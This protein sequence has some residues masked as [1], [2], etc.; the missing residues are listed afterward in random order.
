MPPLLPPD[1]TLLAPV[2]HAAARDRA[3][4]E[5]ALGS[6]AWL[7]DD[8]ARIL[9]EEQVHSRVIDLVRYASDASPYRMFPQIVVT[10]R[11]VQEI[12]QIFSYA[13]EKKL[14][15]TIRAAGS[16]L[17]GQSQGSGI[18]IDVRR[19]WAGVAV[20][21]GG[22]RLRFR[23]G[24]VMF[25]ANLALQPYGYRLGP[26]PASAGVAT[27]GG[28]IANNASG[29]CCGTTQN[30]YNTIESLS[31]L[32]A[33]GTQINTADPDAEHQF[34][35]LE[36]ELAAGLLRIREEI[37][38]DLELVERIRRKYS[39]KNTTGY[40]MAA[41]LDEKSPLNI[42]RRL[43]V[44]SE[45]TLAFISEGVFRTVPDN[46]FRLTA[47]LLFPDMHAACAAVPTFVAASAAAVELCDRE[48]L[49]AVE[50]RPGIPDEWRR[51]PPGAT[52]LL[53][54]F[55]EP[56]LKAIGE[57][58]DKARSILEQLALLEPAE[59]TRNPDLREQ[60][61]AVRH[62]LLPSIGGARASGTSLILEDVCFPK[63]TLADGALDLQ[64]LFSKHSYKGVVFGHASAGNLHFL[65]TPSLSSDHD[66]QL[67]DA[68]LRDVVE[69]VTGKY[70]GSL[71]AEHGT[72]RNIAPFV[73]REW[74]PKLTDMMWRVKRLADP[75]NILSPDVVLTRNETGH[76]Q[77]LHTIPTVEPEID[78]CIEC[79][80]CEPVCPSRHITTTPRQRITLRREMRRQPAGSEITA[81]IL[82][83]YQYDAIETCAGDG[84]C[85]LACPVGIDTGALMKKFRHTEQSGVS[86]SVA[87][88]VAENWA[89]AE[90]F[91]RGALRLNRLAA[92]IPGGTFV[93]ANALKAAR[94]VL[95]EDLIPSI[96][97]NMPG[98]AM[99]PIPATSRKGA[100]AVYYHACVN[101]I[102][103]SQPDKVQPDLAQAL[104]LIS[105]RAQMPVWIPE[106][107][108]GTCCAT[109][110]RSKGYA[111]GNL[112]MANKLVER[113]WE[114]SREGEIPIVC[115]A[116]S[117]SFGMM[118]ELREYLSKL[119][120]K[121][122]TQL[123]IMDSIVWAHDYLLPQ[124]E[125]ERKVSSAAI[126]PTCS[127]RHLGLVSKLQRLA[128]ALAERVVIPIEATCCGFAGDRGFLHPELT[129][130]ATEEH[131]QELAGKQ[132][133]AYVSSNRTCE[134]GMNLATGKDYRSIIFLLEELTR[135][136]AS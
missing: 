14:S 98:P 99:H 8:L 73:E 36:P 126:H 24:T 104:V 63:N 77:Y 119:N 7:R 34:A 64:K 131:A 50:R 81:E 74:G 117:C 33:S 20:E 134:I 57:A 133:D 6:P 31:F 128:E 70:A 49:R 135:D 89:V 26:D 101:R 23:P 16:S 42:F 48:C 35:F 76:L 28:V 10:P 83:D 127:V 97:P 88:K 105:S 111:A 102:F 4:D 32:L 60:Y 129:R 108:A 132:F 106:D 52:A 40:H 12:A 29:M 80:F 43:L 112:F 51:L 54:E 85:A 61:W 65:I 39:I 38:N 124:L 95:S 69:L 19:H 41:F 46:Q 59:F 115:D 58:G 37:L 90:R 136:S 15:V 123:Q 113:L 5:L 78:R 122:H 53:I 71:K 44:G 1:P 86:E 94:S 75:N 87:R 125:I 120:R 92:S 82:R 3:P 72:G 93:A 18:L 2:D 114:W 84:S 79:G 110:W 107:L 103:G 47:F 118:S 130:S 116:S 91:A 9:G 56:T 121:R 109:I 30:S 55:R 68:F 100:A 67:F 66:I 22:A 13:Q 21:E 27:L 96:L 11:S 62:G 45:G 17:S 25:R